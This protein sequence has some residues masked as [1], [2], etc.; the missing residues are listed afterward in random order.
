MNVAVTKPVSHVRV[1]C[2]RF[3]QPFE[4]IKLK[5]ESKVCPSRSKVALFI[6]TVDDHVAAI[7]QRM[8]PQ[9]KV[10]I[11]VHCHYG[12]CDASRF[13]FHVFHFPKTC[14]LVPR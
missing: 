14:S 5:T 10:I 7:E 13:R 6:S 2:R 8:G 11:G 3:D 9:H 12:Q 4:Y 1:F